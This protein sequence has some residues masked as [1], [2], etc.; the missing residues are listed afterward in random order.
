M[1]DQNGEKIY[2][3]FSIEG[4]LDVS[5]GEKDYILEEIKQLLSS[6]FP[7]HLVSRLQFHTNVITESDIAYA[8]YMARSM[9][10]EC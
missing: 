2:I 6:V 4:L 1:S 7:A 3:E 8:M 10:E 5:G 9:N